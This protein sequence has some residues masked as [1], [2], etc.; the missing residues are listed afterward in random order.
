[1]HSPRPLEPKSFCI[2]FA[3]AM[4]ACGKQE[5]PAPE[6]TN[7][8]ARAVQA[9]QPSALVS[10]GLATSVIQGWQGIWFG[11][12]GMSLTLVAKENSK[13]E[14]TIDETQ[15]FE[16]VAGPDYIAFERD[17][18]QERIKATDGEATG[19]KWLADE[20]NCLTIKDGEGYCRK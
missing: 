18:I 15:T 1:M 17:G 14:V 3:L 6:N 8:T 16:G 11:P 2:I 10:T 4:A 5:V 9:P 7:P 20:S 12:E 19:M 13:Y